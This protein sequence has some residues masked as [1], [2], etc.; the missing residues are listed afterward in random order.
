MCDCHR[1]EHY[2]WKI[3]R[4]SSIL[5]FIL[6]S[7]TTILKSFFSFAVKKEKSDINL[8]CYHIGRLDVNHFPMKQKTRQSFNT[9]ERSRFVLNIVYS[10][11]AEMIGSLVHWLI[12][13]HSV[14]LWP[15][16]NIRLAWSLT[17]YS[18]ENRNASLCNIRLL[19]SSENRNTGFCNIWFHKEHLSM[20]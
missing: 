11:L 10:I 4:F 13:I 2:R 1:T 7:F 8:F 19:Y 3:W 5:W 9:I 18:C 17:F 15:S 20:T 14:V 6:L 16:Q 12:I